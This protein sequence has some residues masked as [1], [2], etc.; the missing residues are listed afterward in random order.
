MGVSLYLPLSLS[1]DVSRSGGHELHSPGLYG[2]IVVLSA[3]ALSHSRAMPP[4][5]MPDRSTHA[6]DPAL[7][8][9]R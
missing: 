9:G 8:T 5:D 6:P 4:V 7:E 1:G 2:V 3:Q